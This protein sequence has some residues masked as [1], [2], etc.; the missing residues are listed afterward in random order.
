[1]TARLF[2]ASWS[3]LHQASTVGPLPVQPV[4][5]SRGV[6]RFWPAAEQFPAVDELMPDGW[7]FGIKDLEKFGRCYRRKL[8]AIGLPRVRAL[9]DE[10]AA[11]GR[12][13]ALACFETDPAD[14][15]RGPLG[16]AGWW[17]RKTG[18]RVPDLAILAAA[19]VE[20]GHERR[21]ALVCEYGCDISSVPNVGDAE[22]TGQNPHMGS[23]P[24]RGNRGAA[25]LQLAGEGL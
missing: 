12:P 18:E 4:R 24:D 20:P 8:H 25:Q 1:V 5:I 7:M 17:E 3:A 21:L 22:A 13:L 16:F 9:I 10:I 6:P 11:D 2:T 19:R 23:W 14:C 15:H